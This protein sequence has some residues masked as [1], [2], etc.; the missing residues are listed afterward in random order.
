MS[1]SQVSSNSIGGVLTYNRKGRRGICGQVIG[2]DGSGEFA[3]VI[4]GTPDEA[5]AWATAHIR[6]Q[7]ENGYRFESVTIVLNEECYSGSALHFV[8][9]DKQD[10]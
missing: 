1:D 6:A 8:K 9:I 3:Y 5:N 7:E 4:E 10:D 2:A